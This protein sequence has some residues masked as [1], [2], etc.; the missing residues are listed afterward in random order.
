MVAKL[1]VKIYLMSHIINMIFNLLLNYLLLFSQV[2]YH[3][4]VARNKPCN[5]ISG[6]RIKA[7]ILVA[8]V[9]TIKKDRNG[10]VLSHRNRS[11]EIGKVRVRAT[12]L[13]SPSNMHEG[14]GRQQLSHCP[15]TGHKINPL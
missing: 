4:V 11:A 12:P 9:E 3:L 1:L 7:D 13:A 2:D 5:K 15:D 6:R 10:L 8:L 14:V